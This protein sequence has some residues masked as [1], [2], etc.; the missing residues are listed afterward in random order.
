MEVTLYVHMSC[1]TTNLLNYIFLE[2][3]SLQNWGFSYIASKLSDLQ[4]LVSNPMF[5]L[6][7]RNFGY[8]FLGEGGM[9]KG[10]AAE[11]CM[12]GQAEGQA[13]AAQEQGPHWRE[14]KF[15]NHWSERLRALS[16]N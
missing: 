2:V 7:F 1:V 4:I 13:C 15:T 9:F 8:D 10:D 12:G 5:V 11:T 14:W 16:R 3:V 6:G